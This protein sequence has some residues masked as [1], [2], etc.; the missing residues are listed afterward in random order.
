MSEK[1]FKQ[2]DDDFEH[3][4]DSVQ[5]EATEKELTPELKAQRRKL[6]DVDDF[7]FCKIYFPQ[8]F[9]DSF[10]P[11]H[12][13]IAECKTGFYTVSGCR[14]FGK[15][16]FGYT[17]KFVKSMCIGGLGLLGLG[18]RT[19]S[20]A[21]AR[22]ASLVRLMKR[23]KKLMYDYD[24]NIQQDRIGDYIINFKNLKAFGYREGIRN[25]F[26]EEFNRFEIIIVD[27]LFDRNSVKSEVDNKKVYD[28][29]TS[30]CTGQLRPG[31]L[32]IWF[33]NYCST[34]SPGKEYA[35]AHPETHFNLPALNEEGKTNWPDS[36]W[37]TEELVKLSK[38]IPYEVWMGDYMNDPIQKGD[39]FNT[40]WLNTINLNLIKIAA[41]I[42]GVD[43]SHGQ[44]PAA[45]DKAAI[46][47][48]IDAE[49]EK[50]YITDIYIRKEGFPEFFDYLAMVKINTINHKAICWE[51]D[52]QQWD[53]AS[54]YYDNWRKKHKIYLPIILF[55]AKDNTSEFYGSDK[56]S[57]I[58]NLV[59][60]FQKGHILINA[61][62]TGRH[63]YTVWK[64]QYISFGKNKTRLDGLD[65]TA[66]AFIMLPRYVNTGSFKSTGQ[67]RFKDEETDWLSN[68]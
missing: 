20:L 25:I 13:Y 6:A 30:E 15:S 41:S 27:D 37:T 31:G 53:Y 24:V 58:M 9:R 35:D 34:D 2:L 51:N 19:Q 46:T 11:L 21:E 44:S 47:I 56:E 65:A 52:F 66:S 7:Q 3:Y 55:N 5:F 23:N 18:L 28:F 38:E 59:F 40:D 16:A 63:D 64:T 67:R 14:R 62:I 8:I 26:D 39:I 4:L 1:L 43:P 29:V 42:T 17:T 57:R 54:A 12:F 45:C 61:L 22:T 60:P 32:I 36:F 49:L 50:C 68:R 48:G 10:N 33:F